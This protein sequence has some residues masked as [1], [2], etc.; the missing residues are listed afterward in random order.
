[1][2]LGYFLMLA[3]MTYQAELFLAVVLGLGAGHVAFNVTQPIGESTDACCVDGVYQDKN[4]GPPAARLDV[5][6]VAPGRPE[7][8][9]ASGGA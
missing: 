1:M 2:A 4:P 6:T 7:R 3:A 9:V 8:Q 5:Q